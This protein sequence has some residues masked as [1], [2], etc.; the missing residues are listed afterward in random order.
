MGNVIKSEAQLHKQT[1]AQLG[2]GSDLSDSNDDQSSRMHNSGRQLA[3][4]TGKLK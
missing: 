1:K 4:H 3:G 2:I